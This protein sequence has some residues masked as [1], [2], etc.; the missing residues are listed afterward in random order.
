MTRIVWQP[1]ALYQPSYNFGIVLD[2]TFAKGMLE[3]KL[4]PDATRTMNQMGT[5]LLKG[6]GHN[7]PTPYIF[8]E[9]T[10]FVDQFY[11]AENGVWL[12]RDDSVSVLTNDTSVNT[13]KYSSHNVD[14]TSQ[15]HSLMALVDMW[16]EY[17]DTLKEL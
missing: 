4:S 5:E 16:V 13:I 6:F 12:A 14:N 3:T 11:L 9:D 1:T 7:C 17:A 15:A 2:R 10:A 8:H